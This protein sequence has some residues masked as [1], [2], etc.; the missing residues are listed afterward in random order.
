MAKMAICP[1]CVHYVDNFGLYS[2]GEGHLCD[3]GETI[4][5]VSGLYRLRACRDHNSDGQC[6]DF[7]KN[8][9]FIGRIFR[10]G[11]SIW[12]EEKNE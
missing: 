3:V 12:K 7:S 5:P 6:K 11:K 1:K 8:I 2:V 10:K 4:S 9:S